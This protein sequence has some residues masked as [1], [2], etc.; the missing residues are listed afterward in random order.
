[1]TYLAAYLA[2]MF[3]VAAAGWLMATLMLRPRNGCNGHR[4]EGRYCHYCSWP[5]GRS[6]WFEPLHWGGHTY[7]SRVCALRD[8]LLVGREESR[9]NGPNNGAIQ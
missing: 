3:L 6:A 8:E 2:A 4:Y 1:M 9:R 7:C 5:V